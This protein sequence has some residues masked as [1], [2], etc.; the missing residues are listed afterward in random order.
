[1]YIFIIFYLSSI[2]NA[3]IQLPCFMDTEHSSRFYQCQKASSRFL[4]AIFIARLNSKC[5]YIYIC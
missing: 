2:S 1:M 4:L 3:L 5:A